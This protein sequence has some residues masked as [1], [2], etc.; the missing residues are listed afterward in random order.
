MSLAILLLTLGGSKCLNSVW[1]PVG[2]KNG[3][4]TWLACHNMT[5][6]SCILGATFPKAFLLI[7]SIQLLTE[8]MEMRPCRPNQKMEI[9]HLSFM[10][11]NQR[12]K[13]APKELLCNS[14]DRSGARVIRIVGGPGL[15]FH[16]E[17]R[18]PSLRK[19]KVQGNMPAD[20]LESDLLS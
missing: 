5:L 7:Q 12:L 8:K 6:H 11:E 9:L 3:D 13:P 20:Y 18:S 19:G 16:P 4:P 1:R 15:P 10:N 17:G 14:F 2:C